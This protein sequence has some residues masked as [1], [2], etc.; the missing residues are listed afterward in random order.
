MII[1]QFSKNIILMLVAASRE[2][3][4]TLVNTWIQNYRIY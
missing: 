4:P 3:G 2:E 1:V